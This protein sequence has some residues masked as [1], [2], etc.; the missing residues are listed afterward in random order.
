MLMAAVERGVNLFDTADIYGQ[1]DSERVLGRLFRDRRDKVVFCTKA[2]LTLNSSQTLI[3]LVKP[4]VNPLLRRWKRVRRGALAVRKSS[5]RNCFDPGY[6]RGRV[7]KSLRRL[8]TDYLDLFLLHSPP[9]TVIRESDELFEMLDGLVAGGHIRYYGVSCD[10]VQQALIC[11]QRENIACLQVPLNM[12][13]TE[14]QE[15]LL[16]KAKS[17]GVGIVARE[18]LAGGA[19]LSYPPLLQL[20]RDNP[21]RTPAQT[22]L[23]YLLQLEGVDLVLAGMSCRRHLQENIQALD[24]PPLSAAEIGLLQPGGAV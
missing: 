11:L 12:M 16:P 6:I 15:E 14:M 21:A 9:E 20:C 7:E 19:I 5:E 18:A 17:R 10:T 23:R 8:R 13:E 22:A 3:R 1:G 24:S 2:G 4:V